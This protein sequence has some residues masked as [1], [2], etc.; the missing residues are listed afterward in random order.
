MD[1][2]S[3]VV[4]VVQAALSSREKQLMA[5]QEESAALQV[6]NRFHLAPNFSRTTFTC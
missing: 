4:P 2:V 5:L 1:V 3:R 6:R